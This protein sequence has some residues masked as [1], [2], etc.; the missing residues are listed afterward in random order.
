MSPRKNLQ[1][2]ISAFKKIAKTFHTTS[3]LSVVLDGIRKQVM[4]IID[5]SIKDRVHLL[6]FVTDEELRALYRM[7]SI[8]L[9]PS[10]FEG[11]G[12]TIL[13]AMACETPVIT[14]N[15][16]SLPE[17]A[18]DAA[19]LVDPL[20]EDEISDAIKCVCNDD[21]LANDLRAKGLKR[22]KQLNWKD[23]ARNTVEVYKK[24]LEQR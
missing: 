23:C 18:G 22:A 13:E 12:L 5:D 10:L 14:S 2:V 24:I 15:V 1:G 6:G 17:V 8:Y 4:E 11:F 9:H 16:F 7:A 20:N 21:D 19:I 3:L